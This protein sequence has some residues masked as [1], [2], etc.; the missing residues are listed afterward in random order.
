MVADP[1]DPTAALLTMTLPIV[2]WETTFTITKLVVAVILL[3]VRVYV[4]EVEAPK[5]E[6]LEVIS[7]ETVFIVTAVPVPVAY[8]TIMLLSAKSTP[9][10]AESVIVV[11]ASI[12]TLEAASIS[13]VPPL[14]SLMVDDVTRIR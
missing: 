13:T 6:L 12:V 2:H 4:S 8:P 11:A 1:T 7:P 14:S 9:L 10:V 5:A 3:F